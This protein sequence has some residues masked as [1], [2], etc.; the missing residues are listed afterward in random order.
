MKPIPSTLAAVLALAPLLLAPVA[1]LAQSGPFLSG[2]GA[3]LWRA[4]RL[5]GL[6]VLGPDGKKVGTVSDVL[7]DHDGHAADVVIGVGGFLGLGQKDVALPFA[8]VRFTDAPRPGG[9]DG[10]TAAAQEKGAFLSANG[11]MAGSGLAGGAG[12]AKGAPNSAAGMPTEPGMAAG[13]AVPVETPAAQSNPPAAAVGGPVGTTAGVPGGRAT[14]LAA[15]PA[16][17]PGGTA[18]P[19]RSTARPDH[20]TVDLTADQ[21]KAA[22]AFTFAH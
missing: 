3:D 6:D 19:A 12:A 17:P 11:G 1:A 10:A 20:A 13:S 22:P 15:T 8:Q 16:A 18:A 5:V 14:G 2:E 21:L 4:S 7:M 9:A